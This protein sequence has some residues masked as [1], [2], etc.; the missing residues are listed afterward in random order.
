MVLGLALGTFTGCK[1]SGSEDSPPPT[2]DPL[3]RQAQQ[4][5]D[6]QLLNDQIL[7]SDEV[8]ALVYAGTLE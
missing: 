6:E 7:W 3:A 5:R 8:R 2:V 4:L 1:R